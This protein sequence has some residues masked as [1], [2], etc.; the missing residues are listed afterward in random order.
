MPI[1][2]TGERGRDGTEASLRGFRPQARLLA[3]GWA[4][5]LPQMP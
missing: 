1:R 4:A 2:A 3:S 5:G